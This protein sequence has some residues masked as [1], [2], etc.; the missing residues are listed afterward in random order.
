MAIPK[1]SAFTL[2]ELLVVITIIGILI[3][4]LM[5][6]VHT[7]RES[8]RKAVCANHLHQIGVAYNN[9]YSKLNRSLPAPGWLGELAPYLEDMTSMYFCP[10]QPQS[11]GT[12]AAGYGYII[13]TRYPGGSRKIEC[14]PGTNCRVT[15]GQFGGP[16]YELLFEFD[17][18]PRGDWDDSI[19]RFEDRGDGWTV[20]TSVGNDR[21]NGGPGGSFGTQYFA[22][23]G[24]KLWETKHGEAVSGGQHVGVQP[25]DR[26]ASDYG[27][28]IRSTG[29]T[30]DAHKILV[31]EYF[32][33][34]ADVHYF[35]GAD[36]WSDEV[37]PRH[38][39]TL[40][41]LYVGGHV[42]SHYPNEIDPDVAE[43][44]N[45]YWRPASDDEAP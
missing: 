40:N 10:S 1:R 18:P 27:M 34:I 43:L 5:P 9:R 38:L 35:D 24:T 25:G 4:L 21:P 42:E 20:V 29:M 44:Y 8:G 37:A 7:S 6:A 41:V 3:S 12:T 19:I 11:E 17:D 22:P 23:D 30:Q 15:S 14:R 32:K 36:V 28:N 45:E 31:L 16:I 2:V 33:V 26:P 13:L 39:G